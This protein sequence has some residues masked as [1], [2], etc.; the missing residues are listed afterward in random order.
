[1][2][3]TLKLLLFACSICFLFVNHLKGQEGEYILNN[4]NPDPAR[5]DYRN[6]DLDFDSKGLLHVANHDGI[7]RF[8]GK[9][10]ELI[11]TPSSA[12]AIIFDDENNLFIGSRTGFGKL[13]LQDSGKYAYKPILEKDYSEDISLLEYFNGYIYAAN[14]SY[15]FVYDPLADELKYELSLPE[16]S[17]F[18]NIFSIGEKVFVDEAL[19][20]IKKIEGDSL[21]NSRLIIPD[22]GLVIFAEQ[23]SNDSSKYLIGTTENNL[24]FLKDEKFQKINLL[25]KDLE[26]LGLNIANGIWLSENKLAVGTKTDGCLFIDPYTGEI[27][28]HSNYFTGLPDNE[29]NIMSEDTD[30]GLWVAHEFGFSRIAHNLPVKSFA[31][32]PG[33]EGKPLSVTNFNDKIYL[34]TS[35][36]VYFLEEIRNYKETVYYVEDKVVEENELSPVSKP[37]I[38]EPQQ[39]RRKQATNKKN[40]F[41]GFLKRSK[42]EKTEAKKE[43]N[44]NKGFF[45]FLKKE[46]NERKDTVELS[47]EKKGFLGAIFGGKKDE[48]ESNAPRKK[49]KRKVFRELISVNYEYK[50]VEG[51]YSKSYQMIEYRDHLIV[52]TNT[53]IYEIQDTSAVLISDAVGRYVYHSSSLD[54]L[55]IPTAENQIISLSLVDEVWTEYSPLPYFSEE[56]YRLK[57]DKDGNLWMTGLNE[58]FKISNL[59]LQKPS[60]QTLSVQNKSYDP[61]YILNFEEPFFFNKAGTFKYDSLQSQLIYDSIQSKRF[62]NPR[63]V[64]SNQNDMLW[65]RDD[66]GWKMVN[67]KIDQSVLEYL[68]LF[69]HITH[70]EYSSDDTK[71]W[72]IT[73]DDEL[74]LLDISEVSDFLTNNKIFLR[75]VK[76]QAGESLSSVDLEIQQENSHIIFELAQPEYLGTTEIQYQY[77][78]K[79]LN[80]E[81]SAWSPNNQLSFHYLPPGKYELSVRSRNTFGQVVDGG[82]YYFKV[83][84]PVWQRW[85]FYLLEI[86]FFGSL[87]ILSFRLNR[88]KSRHTVFS[89]VLTFFTLIL[90]LEFI[91]TLVESKMNLKSSPVLDF[92]IEATIAFSILPVERILRKFMFDWNPDRIKISSKNKGRT[93]KEDPANTTTLD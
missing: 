15:V 34:S 78:L 11:E 10:W 79:G 35:I 27:L 31:H 50:K 86:I 70:L 92:F 66:S 84:P 36:G 87:L 76:N 65:I 83:V 40:G 51:L 62:L 4:F 48:K 45:G 2:Y 28:S 3:K 30:G 18:Y 77:Q 68:S 14:E 80:K 16:E 41:F 90:I 73:G 91:E 38:S 89:R 58:V 33:L 5:I 60:I 85:W 24:F 6:Y 57:E 75:K 25:Y 23:S 69:P 71:L 82:P 61:I 39:E 54:E 55:L 26:I 7:V 44:D 59:G 29:I 43:E 64:I 37:A 32:Y 8:D 19:S 46:D 63:K 74:Y 17:I 9:V 13:I 21:V 20:G 47:D 42:K 72:I 49:Y 53:G 81:W 12:L 52:N 93:S 67:S 1:M 56:I 88:I 22:G